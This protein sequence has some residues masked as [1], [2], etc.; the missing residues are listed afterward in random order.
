VSEK[1]S[2]GDPC[3]VARALDVVGERWALL[4]V[5]DLLFGAKRFSD[6]ARGLPGM[7]QN[8]LSARLRD[9]ERAGIVARRRLGP[10]VSAHVYELTPRGQ[11]LEPVLVALA[12]WGS[13]VPLET[14]DA[15]AE[16]SV[17]SLVLALRTTFD[18]S[19]AEGVAARY[20][21]LLGHD[22]FHAEIGPDGFRAGRGDGPPAP[23][24]TIQ[25]DAATLRA[26]VFGGR[27]LDDAVRAGDLR[28]TGDR[29]AAEAF[30]RCFPRPQ[31]A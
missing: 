10:P 16:L 31:P 3:G 20:A 7:S 25:T 28:L 17:D 21:L 22:R 18:P 4:V 24:A 2:Y 27:P 26:V 14:V 13:R 29:P 6:L 15:T 8:V 1:R 12:R 9:L 11:E 19:R 30:V 23:D 5:R